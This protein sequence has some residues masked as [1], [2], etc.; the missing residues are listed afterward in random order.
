MD[1]SNPQSISHSRFLPLAGKYVSRRHEAGLSLLECLMAIIVI[2]LTAALITPA[3]FIATATRVQNR[4]AEQA[5][6]LAQAEVERVQ[7][8]VSRSEHTLENLPQNFNGVVAAP[9]ILVDALPDQPL[10]ITQ[11]RKIDVD[12]NNTTDY[13]MQ[14]FRTDTSQAE[15]E[16]GVLRPSDFNLTVRVYAFFTEDLPELQTQPASLFLTSGEGS[17]RTRPLAVLNNRIVWVDVKSNDSL[18][19]Y[20]VPNSTLGGC[21]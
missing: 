13:F 17:Q 20:H 11:A 15:D 10:D 9:T 3:L 5:L 8:M 16:D 4:R 2:G 12:G 1:T 6:Q 19:T 7:A 18:C 14:V 21:N